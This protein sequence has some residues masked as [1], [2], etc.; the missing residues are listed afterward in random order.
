[1]AA[2]CHSEHIFTNHTAAVRV[3]VIVLRRASLLNVLALPVASFILFP[4]FS[5]R[6]MAVVLNDVLIKSSN[7]QLTISFD[8]CLST[9]SDKMCFRSRKSDRLF[10]VSAHEQVRLS[11]YLSTEEIIS[12]IHQQK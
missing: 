4:S 11:L 12:M 6:L 3:S 9:G 5:C 1:M 10:T 8:C 7:K 2:H